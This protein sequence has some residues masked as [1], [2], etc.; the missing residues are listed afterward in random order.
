MLHRHTDRTRQEQEAE[1]EGTAFVVAAWVGLDTSQY[2]FGYVA[3]WAGTK[4]G[5]ALVKRVGGTIQRT[6]QRIIAALGAGKY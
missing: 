5:P 2:S 1:A 3:D 4:D 6:A